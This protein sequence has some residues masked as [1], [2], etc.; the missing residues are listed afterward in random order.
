V[1]NKKGK[2][3]QKSSITYLGRERE[4]IKESNGKRRV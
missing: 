2:I 3:E 1:L 4:R